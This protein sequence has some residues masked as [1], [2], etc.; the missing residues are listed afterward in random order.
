MFHNHL[1]IARPTTISGGANTCTEGVCLSAGESEQTF[2]AFEGQYLDQL[3]C[4]IGASG[5]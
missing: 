3:V 2:V 1:E 5:L 4:K